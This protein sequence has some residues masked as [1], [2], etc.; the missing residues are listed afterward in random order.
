M[1]MKNTYRTLGNP[2][3]TVSIVKAFSL[4]A[5]VLL[6]CLPLSAQK[7]TV[8][9]LEYVP[10][11]AAAASY[12]TQMQDINGNFAGVVKLKQEKRGTNEY[13]VW[14]A[15]GSNRLKV[16]HPSFLPLEVNFRAYEE[17]KIVKSKLTY[18][19][20]ITVPN[21]EIV[22]K[23]KFTLRYTPA[24]AT[25]IIDD[26]VVEGTNGVYEDELLVGDHSYSIAKKGY[27]VDKGTF[28]L[29]SSA[30]KRLSVE[31]EKLQE[32]APVA[33]SAPTT[34]SPVQTTTSP[35]ARQEATV[36]D[37]E[38]AGKTPAQ[39]RDLGKDYRNGTGGKAQDYAKALKYFRVAVERGNTDAMVDIGYMYNT[40]RGVTQNYS[41][42]IKWFRK[43]AEQGDA[44]GQ[45]MLGNMYENGKGVAQDYAEAVKW[46]RK[47]AEQGNDKGQEHLGD[48]YL[49][50]HGV[51][52]DYSEAIKWFRKSAEQ[53]NAWSQ[54]SLG[55]MYSQGY[56]VT[57]DDVEAVKWYR[58]SAEQGN[59]A[60]QD[61]LGHCYQY[62]KGVSKDLQQARYWYDKAAAQGSEF[63]K[64]QLSE[65]SD[66][67]NA[68]IPT[69][70]TGTNKTFSVNGVSFD[71]VYVEGG[72]FTMGATSEQG[73]DADD[74]EKPA[75]RVTLSSYYIGE[76]EVT[77]EL[78]QAVMGYLPSDISSSSEDIKGSQR[79]MC[80]V[81]WEDCQT[82]I[83][84]LNSL[85]GQQF[86]LPT[87]AQW[88]YAA[89]GGNK[90]R[91]YKYSGSNDPSSVAWYGDIGDFQDLHDVRMK[92]PN[93]QGIYDMSGNAWE[94]CQDW[95]GSYSRNA[96]K[97]PAGASNGYSRVYRGGSCGTFDIGCRSSNRNDDIPSFRLANLGLRLAL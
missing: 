66:S 48:M 35:S 61:N 54:S 69:P 6:F 89:R 7:L 11:D 87:E 34:L 93:E 45:T 40:G 1:N 94:W 57:K 56:G 3:G 22:Q 92:L 37:A 42:A 95:Y 21:V 82:F 17:V 25:V 43:A 68:A 97:N 20:V 41:E 18:K 5:G 76:T 75:H 65:L 81:S 38:I 83:S 80:Y 31:L 15:Q 86:H 67:N 47:A 49:D 46:Y 10:N 79:P 14:M 84:K 70:A 32:A 19:L 91:G 51:P 71:M 96:Q 53:G 85:T 74:D 58:K 28:S 72:T 36:E 12:E 52:K 2:S 9:S 26:Q 8:E 27:G 77:Q 16:I 13:W 59:V 44:Q 90:S 4:L 88:E 39:I 73:S 62:G 63:A 23:Q 29:L 33:Q 30:P 60:G 24:D 64:K 78:W 50:G 55:Y